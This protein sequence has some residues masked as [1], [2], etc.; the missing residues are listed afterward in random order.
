MRSDRGGSMASASAEIRLK[1]AEARP[2]KADDT[3]F[4]KSSIDRAKRSKPAKDAVR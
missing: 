4:A 3:R 2:H 1:E